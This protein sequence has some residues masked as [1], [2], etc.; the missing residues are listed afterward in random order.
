MKALTILQPW[1]SLIACGAK[2]IETRSW[3][4]KYRGPIAI[5]AGVLP[6]GK[7]LK[8]MFPIGSNGWEYHP[9][10]MA[11]QNFTNAVKKAA[12]IDDINVLPLGEI[13]AIADLVACEIMTPELI[14]ML[15]EPERSFGHYEPGRYMWMLENVVPVG[16]FRAKGMQRLWNWE[17]PTCSE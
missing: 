2:K 15:P 9:D 14:A 8:K 6:V 12:S 16:P 1:A 11:M 4:T 3:A 17:V 13:I 5:H 7:T 10:Y